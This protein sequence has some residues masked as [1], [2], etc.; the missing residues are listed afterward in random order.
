MVEFLAKSAAVAALLVATMASQTFVIDNNNGPGTNFTG[1]QT[2]IDNVPDGAVLIVRGSG[3]NYAGFVIVTRSLTLLADPG[4]RVDGQVVVDSIAA[5]QGVNLR[6]FEF[7]G[8]GIPSFAP[9][10]LVTTTSAGPIQLD[11]VTAAPAPTTNPLADTGLRATGCNQLQL[12]DC[13]IR[14]LRLISCNTH[15]TSSTLSGNSSTVLPGGLV[16]PS[17][18]AISGFGG[19]LQISGA[20]QVQGG[21]GLWGGS[22]SNAPGKAA[23]VVGSCDLRVLGGSLSSGHTFGS[24]HPPPAAINVFPGTVRLSPRVTVNPPSTLPTTAMPMLES[25]SPSVG[26]TSV[27]TASSEDGDLVILLLSLPGAPTFLPPFADP[28]WLD[29]ALLQFHSFAVQPSGGAVAGSITVP[30]NQIFLGFSIAWQCVANGPV[31]GLQASNPSI[32]VIH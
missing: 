6:G 7:T 15:I 27:A 23:I 12:R 14:D 11:N 30:N 26:G 22:L 4:V 2:A 8:A 1:I 3:T 13:S 28:F 31:T 19:R 24:P 5:N 25:T 16:R 17:S 21:S 18:S 20:S 29:P 32:H 10:V 9:D